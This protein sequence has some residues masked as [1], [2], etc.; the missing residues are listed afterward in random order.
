MS[1]PAGIK[2]RNDTE[3]LG[4]EVCIFCHFDYESIVDQ[5]VLEFLDGI[6]A[7]GYDIIF[8]TT[9]KNLSES[10]VE[11][12]KARCVAV[13]ERENDG[14]DFGGWSDAIGM[15][16]EVLES[17]N[18]LLANDSVY[19]KPG[20]LKALF[21]M[22]ESKQYD[23]WGLTESYQIKPHVQSYF[24]NYSSRVL[25]SAPF[26]DF[27][28]KCQ[29]LSDKQSIIN[30]YEVGLT[31]I[32]EKKGFSYGSMLGAGKN[33]ASV[34]GMSSINPSHHLWDVLISLFE[35]PMVKI[36][37][38]RDNPYDLDLENMDNFLDQFGFDVQTIKKHLDRISPYYTKTI[39]A[40]D[41]KLLARESAI[42]VI[43]FIKDRQACSGVSPDRTIAQGRNRKLAILWYA[44]K[45]PFVRPLTFL[46]LCKHLV[47]VSLRC[48]KNDLVAAY[49]ERS[50]GG[51]VECPATTLYEYRLNR[52]AK[53][54][55]VV[56]EADC[57]SMRRFETRGKYAIVCHIYYK[58]LY[59]E[60]ATVIRRV[61]DADVFVSLVEGV[62]ES[63]IDRIREDFP[64]SFVQVFP[65]HGRDVY[66][67][68]KFIDSGL[69]YNY[70]AVLK[71][72][73]KLSRNDK[74]GYDFDGEKWRRDILSDLV[75][76]T[77][78]DQVLDAFCKSRQA[79]LLCPEDYIYTSENIGAN[80][81]LLQM[82][83]SSLGM[84]FNRNELKFP[85]GTMFWVKPW[86]LS[87][88]QALS[89]TA[90]DFEPEPI[91]V[92]GLLPHAI[93]RF[94]GVVA[95]K[96]GYDIMSSSS[97]MQA[98]ENQNKQKPVDVIAFYLPQFHP[99]PENNTWW[100][101][102]FTE[103]RNVGKAR[104]A[105]YT[106]NQPR[107]PEELGYYDLR[108]PT[109]MENQASMAEQYGLTAFAF[110]HYWFSGQQKLTL[111]INSFIENDNIDFKYL[112]CWANENWTRSWDGLNRDVL[113]KQNYEQGWARKY[114]SDTAVYLKSEKYYR[115]NGKP[116]LLIYNVS[117]I[118]DCKD[119][120]HLLR[121][122]YK[123]LGVGDIEVIGVRFYN[124][125]DD[126]ELYG[127]DGFSEFPPHRL[128]FIG[129]DR[130]ILPGIAD[131]FE[132]NVFSYEAVA[133][134]RIDQ[135]G[136][137]QNTH[138]EMGVMCGWDN[139]ARRSRNPDIFHGATPGLFRKWFKAAYDE[140]VRKSADGRNAMLFINAWNEW[141]EGAYLEP[142]LKYGR[143]F[144]EA[145]KSVV[146]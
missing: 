125:E 24:V 35:S 95:L 144:L 6:K 34:P 58:E 50:F 30:Q 53:V 88:I 129:A 85:A 37:L 87:H 55:K 127:I 25:K 64:G 72:H 39:V 7:A 5:Y 83:C 102:G 120:M 46:R 45:M 137:G 142:D 40:D 141:A 101:K 114:A 143:A 98:V 14:L 47:W 65:N 69:L 133:D 122:T 131:D 118:P 15:F 94:V 113:L 73:G 135:I 97:L 19:I 77:N 130:E 126:A 123:G 104:P 92:D 18:L 62:S 93:E 111:P 136:R 91:I 2:F 66:P 59:D 49:Y 28:H 82:L 146:E 20:G 42:Q 11:H 48:L 31:G 38:L 17:R 84:A 67:F 52:K 110:Y 4:S 119:S 78:L 132:G 96:A 81:P 51:S 63:L 116:I 36:E 134:S 103:W 105:F 108:M 26:R 8:V 21:F 32:L 139:S 89:L 128:D 12:L 106:H 138:L 1:S 3:A 74:S 41:V 100:G 109:V 57:F 33:L 112:L 13:L 56:A 76:E 60:L 145:V 121:E 90:D 9:C 27:W 68:I 80:E 54:R 22:M 79:G 115:R 75:P 23:F 71:I 124:V 10:D 16:P 99:I 29:N 86:L 140:S 44:L 43:D 117:A 70:Q 107:I 61:P